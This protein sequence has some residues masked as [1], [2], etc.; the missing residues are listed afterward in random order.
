MV[1][2]QIKCDKKYNNKINQIIYNRFDKHNA[3]NKIGR[4]NQR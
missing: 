1:K 2:S 3:E 4:D